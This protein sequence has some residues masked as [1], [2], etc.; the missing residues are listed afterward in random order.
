MLDVCTNNDQQQ[1]DEITVWNKTW[2]LINVVIYTVSSWNALIL[3]KNFAESV[4]QWL[5]QIAG[6]T[7]QICTMLKDPSVQRGQIP[8]SGGAPYLQLGDQWIGYDDAA[9][10]STK[11]NPTPNKS[12]LFLLYCLKYI[13]QF[14]IT[15]TSFCL[16]NQIS[17]GI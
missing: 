6:V 7:F 3:H 10:I 2:L 1:A 15:R 13:N 14:Y 4:P 12:R 5:F 16:L 9:Y 17:Q 8:G 11:V